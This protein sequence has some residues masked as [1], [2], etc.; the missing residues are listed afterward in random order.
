MKKIYVIF[1]LILLS[2]VFIGCNAFTTASTTSGASATTTSGPVV[3]SSYATSSAMGTTM[4]SATQTIDKS[5][6][7]S[8]VYQQIYEQVYDQVKAQVA[9]DLSDQKF[10]EIYTA[11]INEM[12][13][14]I[15]DGTYQLSAES[16][17]DMIHSV[18]QNA[19][20][21]VIGVSNLNSQG[22]IQAVGSGIIYKHVGSRY[23][24]VTNNHVVEDGSSYQIRFADGSTVAATLRGTDSLVDIAVLYFDS[25]ET[26]PVATFADSDAAQKG[27]LVLAV[28]N[29]SGYDFY[30]SM[31][32][33]IISGTNRYFDIDGDNIK[34]LFVG[35]IQ[36][37]AAINA[38][39]SG[40]ALFDINGKVLG[41]NVIKIADVSVE[42]MGFAIP[43]NLV[44]AVCADI[45]EYG[46]SIQ[47]PMLGIQFSDLTENRDYLITNGATIP[48]DITG[49]F[50]IMSV[51][52]GA[53]L[54]GIVQPDDIITRIADIDLNG[55]PGT[56]DDISS[57]E[58]IEL[59]SKYKVGDVISIDV[60]RSGQT[61]TFNNITLKAKV[62]D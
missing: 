8:D 51:T 36:H 9:Q 32:M 27:D 19:A 20:K 43:G 59:F 16:L 31:T 48:D 46:Y 11:L 30:N 58:F 10:D 2:F 3:T 21:T 37:D 12:K 35:Y 49:G 39:N 22:E 18:V 56:A 1:G 42:G 14:G 25:D 6:L 53:T 41:I 13:A 4:P 62:V 44:Q 57:V 52:S 34:D 5:A 28:G 24:V 47:K 29:P 7:I 60:Y 55:G 17:V 23:Y 54:D 15:D 26:Y 45:E 40:G 33:G 61:L 38:G 50:Y